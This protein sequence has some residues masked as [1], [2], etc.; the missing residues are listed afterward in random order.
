MPARVRALDSAQGAGEAPLTSSTRH[1]GTKAYSP[2]QTPLLSPILTLPTET[3]LTLL[4]SPLSRSYREPSHALTE[5]PLTLLPRPLLRSYRDPFCALTESP[6]T[7]LLR[8]LQ[9]S[10][11]EPFY[12]LTESPK[13]L[14]PR[15]L[16]RSG[17]EPFYTPTE[18]PSVYPRVYKSV[19][20]GIL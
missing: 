7:L 5:S 4:P 9:R 20:A 1:S 2:S 16:I 6:P 14:R 12:T 11:R 3:P 15:A 19:H 13:T 8:A 17:R 10:Y 18:S